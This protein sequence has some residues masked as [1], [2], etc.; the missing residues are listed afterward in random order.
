MMGIGR[1]VSLEPMWVRKKCD[2]RAE[3]VAA[4]LSLEFIWSWQG[5]RLIMD[6]RDHTKENARVALLGHNSGI[7]AKQIEDYLSVAHHCGI[8]DLAIEDQ[9]EIGQ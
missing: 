5:T 1:N 2:T 4:K 8:V 6:N 3:H 9:D 7:R